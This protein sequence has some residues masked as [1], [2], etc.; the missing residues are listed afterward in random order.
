[1][2]YEFRSAAK[3]GDLEKVQRLLREGI[4]TVIETDD[5][6]RNALLLA[7]LS[8]RFQTAR[9]LLEY[10]GADVSFTVNGGSVWDAL[11]RS[12]N[13]SGEAVALMRVVL[14]QGDP[15]FK[16]SSSLPKFEIPEIVR[17]VQERMWLRAALPAYLVQRRALLD[18][19]CPLIP[20]LQDLVASYAKPSA[21]ELWAT[22]IGAAE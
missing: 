16:I 11:M 21:E 20:P 12:Y 2:R 10:G 13:G 4:A 6:G 9:W 22:G 7:T 5:N 1:M 19:H 15:P 8:S 3:A 14:L 17:M 18:G